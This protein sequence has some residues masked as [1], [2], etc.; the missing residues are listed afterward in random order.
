MDPQAGS[1]PQIKRQRI[2]QACDFCHKRGLKCVPPAPGPITIEGPN[3]TSDCLTCIKYGQLCTRLRQ[4]K[5]RG[6]K[7][8][9]KSAREKP[10]DYPCGHS[11]RASPRN[12]TPEA[13]AIS[14]TENNSVSLS[15]HHEQEDS[16]KPAPPSSEISHIRGDF[17]IPEAGSFKSRQNITALMDIYLDSTYPL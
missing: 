1:S 11:I 5:K 16:Q 7:P 13:T 3:R 6:T 14:Y 12:D 9:P 8:R 4:P 10:R 15:T 17:S 2:S